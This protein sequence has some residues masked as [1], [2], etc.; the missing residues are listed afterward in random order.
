MVDYYDKFCGCGCG[1]RI[2]VNVFHCGVVPKYIKN[3]D[4]RKPRVV[5]SC[6]CGCSEEFVCIITS[7]RRFVNGHNGRWVRPGSKSVVNLLPES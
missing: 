2:P 3:H 1:E 7:K 5:R 6:E 4:K